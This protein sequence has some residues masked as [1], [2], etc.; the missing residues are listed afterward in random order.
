MGGAHHVDDLNCGCMQCQADDEAYDD[1]SDECDCW[2]YEHIDPLTGVA[3]CYR[4][5][6]RRYLSAEQM[7]QVEALQAEY[8][9]MIERE[10][11]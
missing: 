6:S 9:E 4:C 7:R 2:E 10:N 8:D 1:E 3:S 11:T 5:G